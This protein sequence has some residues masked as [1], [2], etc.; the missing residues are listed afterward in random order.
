VG[1]RNY[2]PCKREKGGEGRSEW[3]VD[4]EEEKSPS[5]RKKARGASATTKLIHNRKSYRIKA[6][7]GGEE[8]VPFF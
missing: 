6:S 3:G 1:G 4:A 8:L 5:T 7:N 2:L